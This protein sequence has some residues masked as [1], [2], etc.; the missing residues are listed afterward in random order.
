MTRNNLKK[1]IIITT[2]P[3][4]YNDPL[5]K[6]L[7]ERAN[8]LLTVFYTWGESVQQSKFD[9][10]FGQVVKWDIDLLKGYSFQFLE[11]S[12]KQPGSHHFNGIVNPDIITQIDARQPD[13]IL[14]YG[15]SFR[16]HLKVLRYY[17]NKIPVFFRGDST[18]LDDK[19]GF[20]SFVRIIFL[21]WVYRHVDKALYVGQNNKA[22][23]KKVGLKEEQLILASHAVNNDFFLDGDGSYEKE[24]REWRR[25][26]GIS[27]EAV[28][29]LFVGKLEGKKS[30]LL[31]LE[32][33]DSASFTKETH[34]I[35]VGNGLLEPLL[36]TDRFTKNIHFISF[37]NQKR[38][39]VVYRLA[40]IL[41]LPSAGPGETWGLVLNE[42]MACGRAVIASTRCGG[43][44]DLIKDG[45]NGYLFGANNK[46]D[47]R[48]RL[49]EI[50]KDKMRIKE[51]GLASLEHI[52]NFSLLNLA[53]TIEG[54]MADL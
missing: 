13:A 53:K 18:L 20:R 16:S 46:D 26:L 38:M 2:H 41:V 48:G 43:A 27:D 47:L 54:A 25:D 29:F 4:Q 31:L 28:V 49:Q 40:E 1:L 33:F 7:A 3:I 9:P 30:P 12:S 45:V 15:W 35:I 32:A 14:V 34:L 36:K 5:F 44:V 21:A 37:Q 22:Y 8:I 42:A 23:F 6:L 10:G 39:P 17:K 11:N 50:S 52:Q 19:P 51:M 24:A